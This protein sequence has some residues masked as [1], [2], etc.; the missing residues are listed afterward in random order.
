MID[1]R[2]HVLRM[3]AAHGT[4]TGAAAALHYTPSAVSQQLRSLARELGTDLVVQ[5]GRRIR[6]TA[7][8]RVL[9]AHADDLFSTWEKIRSELAADGA[10]ETASLRLCG[11]STAAA[12]LL[13]ATVVRVRAARPRCAVRIIE[14]EPE[15]CFDLLL[16]D[17]AD[18][19]VVV[20]TAT[21]P[22]TIDPRF[23]QQHLLD[24]PLDLVVPEEHRLAHE[25]SVQLSDTVDECWI[26]DRPGRPYHQLMQTACAAAGFT[27]AIAHY[28]SEWDTGAALVAAGLGVCLA[29]RLARLPSN[30]PITR[31]PLRG[32]PI[33]FRHILTAVRRGSRTHPVIA[34]ALAALDEIAHGSR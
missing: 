26:S 19:A 24:D 12:A 32:D 6:L 30:Y 3:V 29:P 8:A 5:D 18:L 21:I 17:D 27:P 33:P 28:S 20:A 13:P 2:L 1:R 15:E 31:V 25:A 14:A 11:F 34:T 10:N 22:P 16:A 4:V 23:D 9:L 7:A